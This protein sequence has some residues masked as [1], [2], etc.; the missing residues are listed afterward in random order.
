[1]HEFFGELKAPGGSSTEWTLNSCDKINPIS[2]VGYHEQQKNYNLFRLM[3][4]DI[5]STFIK[6]K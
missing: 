5:E 1:M 3:K 6:V 4:C 2:L